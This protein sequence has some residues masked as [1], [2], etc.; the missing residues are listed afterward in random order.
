MPHT[1]TADSAAPAETVW[2][3]IAEPNRWAEWAPHMRGAWG[4]GS[5]EVEKWRIGAA[6]LFGV[7]PVPARITAKRDGRSWAW[8]VGPMGLDHAVEPIDGG[9]RVS[10]TLRA[11]GPLEP[12]LA[13][14]YGPVVQTLVQRLARVATR[15]AR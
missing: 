6:R 15:S 3:L 14:T 4:L 12:L 11:A 1:Y 13:A 2:S 8:R 10:M 5:P 9:S 7:L